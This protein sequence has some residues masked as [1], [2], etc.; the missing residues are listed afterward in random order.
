MFTQFQGKVRS[1]LP[2][3][4]HHQRAKVPAILLDAR[5]LDAGW[6]ILLDGPNSVSTIL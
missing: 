5:M 2:S 1:V 4:V 3:Q 6:A